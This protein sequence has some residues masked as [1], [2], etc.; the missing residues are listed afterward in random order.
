[1]SPPVETS[2]AD[3]F[4]PRSMRKMPTRVRPTASA[5]CRPSGDTASG[6]AA[7][8]TRRGR[9]PA[10]QGALRRTREPMLR[11]RADVPGEDRAVE[12]AGVQRLPVRAEDA[13]SHTSSVSGQTL[14]DCPR[15]DV[16]HD[17]GS[18]L[19][20]PSRGSARRARSAE[21][22]EGVRP[23]SPGLPVRRSTNH[24]APDLV[25]SERWPSLRRRRHSRRRSRAGAVPASHLEVRPSRIDAAVSP[26]TTS[27]LPV[28]G[29]R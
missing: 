25:G 20:H 8:R 4:A 7:L 17:H 15:C 1:M 22:R 5:N 23:G 28:T 12:A 21:C 16:P 11:F 29:W 14:D 3:C 18:V 10:S 13:A 26:T 2:K 19:R 24:T 27:R 9:R 6:G